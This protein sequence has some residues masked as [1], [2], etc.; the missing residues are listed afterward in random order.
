MGATFLLVGVMFALFV[1]LSLAAGR[2]LNFGRYIY[3]AKDPITFWAAVGCY[4]I[5]SALAL[6]AA[7]ALGFRTT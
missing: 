6:T 1:A 3:R 5:G 2:I 4:A 7:Y